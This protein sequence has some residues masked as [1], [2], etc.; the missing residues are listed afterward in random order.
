MK[1]H[2]ISYEDIDVVTIDHAYNTAGLLLFSKP[3]TSLRGK[4][5]AQYTVAAA[6]LDGK[7]DIDTYTDKRYPDSKLDEAM[8]KIRIVIHTDWSL[9]R[10]GPPAPSTSRCST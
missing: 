6:I 1:E 2:N 4:F 5:S 3:D 10:P 7:I 8:E 9:E